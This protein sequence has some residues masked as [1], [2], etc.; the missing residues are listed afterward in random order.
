[1]FS[2]VMEANIIDAPIE[3]GI[4]W[5]TEWFSAVPSSDLV[6]KIAHL[7]HPVIKSIGFGL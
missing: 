5:A 2:R 1:M 3:L 7:V 4:L 6:V